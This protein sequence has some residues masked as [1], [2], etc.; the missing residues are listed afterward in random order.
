MNK[1]MVMAISAGLCFGAWPLFLMRSGLKGNVASLAYGLGGSF[2][3][4]LVVLIPLLLKGGI[5]QEFSEFRW[6]PFVIAVVLGMPALIMFNTMLKQA[7]PADAG[8]LFVIMV[9]VQVCVPAVYDCIVN[10]H[11][12][13]MKLA[14]F[15]SAVLTVILL[16]LSQNTPK[17]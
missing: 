14:A 8:K 15:A 7:G 1:L 2:M 5:S 17:T 3:L 11:I 6:Q 4:T 9:I 12:S 13:L 16:F 10:K